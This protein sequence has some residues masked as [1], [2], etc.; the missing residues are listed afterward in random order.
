M[1]ETFEKLP[2][3]EKE[4]IFECVKKIGERYQEVLTKAVESGDK[5]WVK[6]ALRELWLCFDKIESYT[7]QDTMD[8]LMEKLEEIC[9]NELKKE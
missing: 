4:L 9:E 8:N 5:V 1:S 2:Q 7:P 6:F 3:E